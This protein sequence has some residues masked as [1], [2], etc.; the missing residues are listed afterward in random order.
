MP[1]LDARRPAVTLGGVIWSLLSAA[2]PAAAPGDPLPACPGTPNCV[3][4]EPGAPDGRR[5]DP[6][7]IGEGDAPGDPAAA[8]AALKRAV[9]RAGGTIKQ[10]AKAGDDC[11]LHA[12]VKTPVLRFPDDLLARLNGAAGVIH[13][14]SSSRV[15]RSDL[16]ANRRR[17]EKLRAHYLE[18]L[19]R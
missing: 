16:G 7:P 3:C 15:G 9:S 1:V 14:R 6:L 4:S 13:V 5:V 18:E 12:V 17:V 11:V 2:A 8:W 10:D 19:N